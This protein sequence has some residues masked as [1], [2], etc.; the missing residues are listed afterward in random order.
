MDA[1][2]AWRTESTVEVAEGQA[3]PEP[4]G[5]AAITAA[6]SFLRSK[7]ITPKRYQLD[8]LRVKSIFSQSDTSCSIY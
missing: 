2:S 7:V 6:L 5:A 4:A 3:R 1:R 8:K